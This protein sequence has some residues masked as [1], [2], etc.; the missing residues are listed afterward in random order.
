MGGDGSKSRGPVRRL[1][2]RTGEG[3]RVVYTKGKA[4]TKGRDKKKVGGTTEIKR[5]FGA[6]LTGI[7]ESLNGGEDDEEEEERA[8][9]MVGQRKKRS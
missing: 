3:P 9:G 4:V 7:V 2:Y 8:G 1:L 5:H 6:R